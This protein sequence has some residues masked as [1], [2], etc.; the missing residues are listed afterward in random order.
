SPERFGESTFRK[1]SW[2]RR[3]WQRHTLKERPGS[4][5]LGRERLGRTQSCRRPSSGSGLGR[6][7]RLRPKGVQVQILFAAPFIEAPA[8]SA[9][10]GPF[11]ENLKMQAT[12]S[13]V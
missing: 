8:P 12:T 10:P 5:R 1:P 4:A 3:D 11:P 7:V 13:L 9:P 2:Q 6:W